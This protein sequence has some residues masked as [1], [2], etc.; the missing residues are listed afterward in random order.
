MKV[1]TIFTK[2]RFHDAQTSQIESTEG[3]FLDVQI[4]QQIFL[5]FNTMF[6]IFYWNYSISELI[7]L[8]W[9]KSAK[10]EMSI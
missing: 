10:G 4:F 5:N 3:S 6:R 7:N 2:L 8:H 9:V 1:V